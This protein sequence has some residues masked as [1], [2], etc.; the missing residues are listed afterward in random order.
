MDDLDQQA[1]EGVT[2]LHGLMWGKADGLSVDARECVVH[3][4][5]WASFVL[6]DHA[7]WGDAEAGQMAEFVVRKDEPGGSLDHVRQL[8]PQEVDVLRGGGVGA[9]LD[10]ELTLGVCPRGSCRDNGKAVAG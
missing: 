6:G 2:E 8:V 10:S 5:A 1:L 7:H 9:P 3:N 4:G